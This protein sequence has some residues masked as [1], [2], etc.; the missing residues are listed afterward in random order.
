MT[1]GDRASSQNMGD[2]CCTIENRKADVAEYAWYS[3]TPASS[4]MSHPIPGVPLRLA[5]KRLYLQNRTE[6]KCSVEMRPVVNC[7]RQRP[8]VEE[9]CEVWSN[10]VIT[11]SCHYCL[12]GWPP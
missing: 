9:L 8:E 4:S 1:P 5:I 2:E 3:T 11:A 12:R 6:H 10:Q 7:I